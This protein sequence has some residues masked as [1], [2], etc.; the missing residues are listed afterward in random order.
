MDAA[1]PPTQETDSQ[2]DRPIAGHHSRVCRKPAGRRPK[3]LNA[4]PPVSD[5]LGALVRHCWPDFNRWLNDLPDPRLR[6]MCR[7][8]GAHLWWTVLLVFLTRGESRNAFDSCRHV[9]FMP[10]HVGRLCGQAWDK[11]RLGEE[12]TVT[13]TQ[14][15]VHHAGRVDPAQTGRIL[16]CMVRRLMKMRV[17]DAGRLFGTWWRIAIDA[18]L[19]QRSGRRGGRKWRMVLEARLIGPGGLDLPLMVEF[20]DVRNPARDKQD[21]ELKGFDRLSR[22]LKAEFP[23]LPICLL[24]DGLYA[25]KAVFDRCKEFGWKIS[26]CSRTTGMGWSTPFAHDHS[27]RKTFTSCCW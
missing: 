8:S 21:C 16:L 11:A 27:R 2:A 1:I 6:E 24:L 7:Y 25:V 14:N 3:A 22:R 10:E 23:R 18:T 9:G 13:C 5:H 19:Q 26:T 17:L 20:L 12:R 15:A 4:L